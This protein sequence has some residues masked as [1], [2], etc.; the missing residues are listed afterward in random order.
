[1]KPTKVAA[2]ISLGMKIIP[3][4]SPWLFLI[5]AL[6]LGSPADTNHPA[7][8]D[9]N[10]LAK[11][12]TADRFAFAAS[13]KYNPYETVSIES[14]KNAAEQF[15][16]KKYGKAIAQAKKGLASAPYDIDLLL[17]LAAAYRASGD[18]ANADLTD[19]QWMSLV[20]SILGSG[21]GRSFETAFQVISVSEEYAVLRTLGLEVTGQSLVGHGSSKFDL[22]QVQDPRTGKDLSFYFNVD[23]PEKWLLGQFSQSKK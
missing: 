9:R 10:A 1:M 3:R 14:R 21:D 8:T 5:P 20:D 19:N 12:A 11:Q 2:S 7:P 6:I 23:R 13:S 22:M 17:I 18:V 4:L 16:K 15:K